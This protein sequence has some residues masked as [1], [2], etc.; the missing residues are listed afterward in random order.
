VEA[1]YN[2]DAARG[3]AIYQM[4]ADLA[5]K[6]EQ[7]IYDFVLD[8]KQQKPLLDAQ[9]ERALA[10]AEL[11]AVQRSRSADVGGVGNLPPEIIE[12][13]AQE[14]A[15]QATLGVLPKHKGLT[16]Q[17]AF[18]IAE[19]L[20]RRKG[21]YLAVADRDYPEHGVVRGQPVF[22]TAQ[23]VEDFT[24]RAE[25]ETRAARQVAQAAKVAPKVSAAAAGNA[26]V[27]SGGKPKGPPPP[28]GAAASATGSAKPKTK[29]EYDAYMRSKYGIV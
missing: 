3:A 24:E 1:R 27:V 21:T 13:Q 29:D 8:F 6:S 22:K 19:K 25:L 17:Q 5:S 4:F 28:P 10:K 9:V 23:W 7:E 18:D 12:Q 2:E 11:E 14:A 26:A 20:W 15:W 16:Q